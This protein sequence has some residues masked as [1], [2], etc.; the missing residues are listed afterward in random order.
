MAAPDARGGTLQTEQLGRAALG[1]DGFDAAHAEGLA[2]D[3]DAAV[4][5]AVHARGERQRP[6]I[7]WDGAAPTELKSSATW[8][9]AGPTRRS[10]R[11]S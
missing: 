6:S 9:P 1:D 10:P 8:P 4:D 5:Y 2:L 11:L 3:L 7:G